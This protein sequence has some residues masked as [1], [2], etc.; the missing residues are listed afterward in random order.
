MLKR[1][2]KPQRNTRRHKGEV[3]WDQEVLKFG[4]RRPRRAGRGKT[5]RDAKDFN[6][7]KVFMM[8]DEERV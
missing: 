1:V 5:L 6:D 3:E 8:N 2:V 4:D 7:I